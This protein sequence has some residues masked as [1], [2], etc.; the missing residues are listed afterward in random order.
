MWEMLN[1]PLGAYNDDIDPDGNAMTVTDP[2]LLAT[3]FTT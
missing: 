2:A 3:E 1:R